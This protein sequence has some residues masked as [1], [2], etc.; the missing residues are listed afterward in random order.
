M[1]SDSSDGDGQNGK[2]KKRLWGITQNKRGSVTVTVTVTPN[3]H[4]TSSHSSHARG[5]AHTPTCFVF[6]P[7]TIAQKFAIRCI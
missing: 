1:D 4:A 5:H 2:E 6:F 7:K 3:A